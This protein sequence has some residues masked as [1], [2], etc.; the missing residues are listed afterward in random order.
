MY[1]F[2]GYGIGDKFVIYYNGDIPENGDISNIDLVIFIPEYTLKISKVSEPKL[3]EIKMQKLN[4]KLYAYLYEYENTTY[5]FMSI[6]EAIIAY[7]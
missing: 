7:L 4:K 2:G 5:N 6:E 1:D 3:E